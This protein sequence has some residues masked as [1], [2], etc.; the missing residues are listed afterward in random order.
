VIPREGVERFVVQH[1]AGWLPVLE[2]GWLPVLVVI[3]REGVESD[4]FD[5][6][7]VNITDLG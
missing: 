4:L 5:T 2:A 7:R 6:V 1:E 3:P